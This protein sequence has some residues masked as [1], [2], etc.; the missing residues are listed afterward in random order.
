MTYENRK[1]SIGFGNKIKKRIKG[2][3]KPHTLVAKIT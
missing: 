3:H 1:M 2:I